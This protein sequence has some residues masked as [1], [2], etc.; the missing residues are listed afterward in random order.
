MDTVAYCERFLEF[1]VDLESQLPTRRY[2][3]ALIQDLNLLPLIRL[4]VIFNTEENG[5]F[6]DLFTL[7]RHFVN[8]PIDDHSGTPLSQSEFF[9]NRCKRLARLQR[10]A[11]RDFKAKLTILALSNYGAID[12]RSDL[13]GHLEQLEDQELADLARALGFRVD[14]PSAAN[15]TVNRDLLMEI[16]VSAHEKRK[17]FQEVVRDLSVMPTEV[18]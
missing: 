5:L 6:R 1:L 13:E 12:K 18:L 2:V 17:T 8:F 7:L 16:L 14:Y 4:S 10:T 15:V 9:E 11:L 3:N